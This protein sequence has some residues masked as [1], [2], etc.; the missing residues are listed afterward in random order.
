[1]AC[2]CMSV[3]VRKYRLSEFIQRDHSTALSISESAFTVPEYLQFFMSFSSR[4]VT[5]IRR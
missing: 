1:M 3:T 2:S 5:H 4:L